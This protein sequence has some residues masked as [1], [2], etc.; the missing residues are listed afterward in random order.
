MDDQGSDG[1]G[2]RAATAAVSQ[3]ITKAVS[4]CRQEVALAS[5]ITEGGHHTFSEME[6]DEFLII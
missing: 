5:F 1:S 6:T 2:S 3:K 4:L